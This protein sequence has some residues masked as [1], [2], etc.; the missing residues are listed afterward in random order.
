MARVT[1]HL[2]CQHSRPLILSGSLPHLPQ[3]QEAGL[4][5][6]SHGDV[7]EMVPVRAGLSNRRITVIW[8]PVGDGVGS[9]PVAA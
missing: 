5:Q 6:H 7:K 3:G 8:Y 1:A 2:W 4:H 9:W